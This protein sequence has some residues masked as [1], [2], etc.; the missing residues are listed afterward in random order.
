[1][2]D[3]LSYE[4]PQDVDLILATDAVGALKFLVEIEP[5]PNDCE[6]LEEYHKIIQSFEPSVSA[7]KRT[8]RRFAEDLE[9]STVED[10]RKAYY[11]MLEQYQDNSFAAGIAGSY[12]SE[13]MH[14]I[15][16]WEK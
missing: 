12:L 14:G 9:A 11:V 8:L 5:D 16:G 13:A 3:R 6:T 4:E 1:M 7:A 2:T 10:M 15:A